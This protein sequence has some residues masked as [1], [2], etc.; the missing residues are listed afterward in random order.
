M[1]GM[2]ERLVR[3]I[4]KGNNRNDNHTATAGSVAS[5]VTT[6]ICRLLLGIT[7]ILSGFVKSIDPLGTQYKLNDYIEA[8]GLSD[9]SAE[10]LTLMASVLLAAVEFWLGIC[11][12]FA[13]GRRRTS[14]LMLLFMLVMTPMTLWLAIDNPISDCGCFGDAVKLTNWQTFWKNMVLTAAAIVVCRRPLE[15]MR[16]VSKSNQWIVTN[17]SAVFI[18]AVSSW[19]LYDLPV[20]DFR[21]YHVGADI[22]KGMEIP[23]GAP[24]PRFE[25]TLT[26][27]KDGVRKEFD[28]DNCPDSTWTFIDSR[29]VMVEEGYTPPIHDFSIVRRSDGE[30]ITEAVLDNKGYTFLLIAPH[31]E[32]ANDS[33][34]D[35]IN[36][37]YE[38]AEEYG[39]PFYCL[40]A[41]GEKGIERWKIMTGAEYDFCTT[42]ET[43]L[44]TIVR[45]N[46]GLILLKN[47]VITG[48]WSHNRLPDEYALTG[49]LETNDL[50]KTNNDSTGGKTARMIL[51]FAVPL[52]LL[53]LADRTWAW[54]K[55]LRK[56]KKKT[57][58]EI[59][60]D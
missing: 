22:R 4:H 46:P 60:T 25:T 45:S 18:I 35:L 15:M 8:W 57:E 1:A 29:S 23:E 58:H 31:L 5:T 33:N 12:L 52:L 14:M 37:L 53:T 27:E 16:F 39:Y 50:G 19:S 24:M 28:I 42:D 11:M 32:K 55:W 3:L 49:P 56:R 9:Y 47:G 38:Y 2:K 13:I 41:S 20:F 43:T 30:D 21:P 34:L 59:S 7:F 17:Y 40:T 6:N 54:T 48:K 10:A 36:Q 44:K 51:W 26:Y